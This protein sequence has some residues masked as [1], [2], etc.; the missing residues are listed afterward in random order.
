[1]LLKQRDLA[2]KGTNDPRP[3]RDKNTEQ[4][5]KELD[6]LKGRIDLDAMVETTMNA[7]EVSRVFPMHVMSYI[8]LC[9]CTLHF[10]LCT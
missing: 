7:G 3:S 8:P 2:T 4:L 9:I 1:M 6:A 5:L 10:A